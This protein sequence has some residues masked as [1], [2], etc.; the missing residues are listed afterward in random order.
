MKGNLKTPLTYYGGKQTMLPA[1]LPLIPEHSVYTEAY[2]GGCAVLFAKHP[3]KCEI[4][5]DLNGELVN[6]YRVCQLQPEAL[7]TEI[8]CS[9][10]SRD[11][12]AHANHIY[13][14]PAFFNPVQRAWAVWYAL[15]CSFSAQIGCGF[16]YD[17]IGKK[18]RS[19]QSAITAFN[20]EI[21]SRIR[22]IT[23][24]RNE[25]LKVLK[26][27]DSPDTFHFIDP[28]YVGCNMGH[29]SGMFNEQSLAE[30]LE[31]C[32]GLQGKFMLTMY[33]N[34]L[35]RQSADAN[36][37]T[38]HSVERIVSAAKNRNRRQEEWMVCNYSMEK[39]FFQ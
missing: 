33:S 20:E 2:A 32:A 39:G 28:P 7:Q 12:H 13:K 16:S 6:F 29:Y 34:E 10:H 23:I 27:Y 37:W 35:I 36:Q 17:T 1:I 25:A 11:L 30:L 19:I 9:L 8:E 18:S 4:I 22:H 31:L 3:V 26:A 24:E 5:N 38:I 15:K 14:Y 21:I